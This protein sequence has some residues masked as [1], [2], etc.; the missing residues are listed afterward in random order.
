MA[1]SSMYMT[2]C[3]CILVYPC[4][5]GYILS[6]SSR[7]KAQGSSSHGCRLRTTHFALSRYVL[8]P[9]FHFRSRA[10]IY[11]TAP[12]R[13]SVV[14]RRFSCHNFSGLDFDHPDI[15]Q[16]FAPKEV[17]VIQR[18][19]GTWTLGKPV[20]GCVTTSATVL[21]ACSRKMYQILKSCIGSDSHL[22]T[23]PWGDPVVQTMKKIIIR[24]T[25]DYLGHSTSV[26]RTRD[27][28]I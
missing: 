20:L 19:L 3:T 18:R 26:G 16:H 15:K 6:S 25:R 28:H 11:R 1:A 27:P 17:R 21:P 4:V 23:V 5:R 13:G 24:C 7:L 8:Y 22:V 2:T 14:R 9:Q 12:G 10:S